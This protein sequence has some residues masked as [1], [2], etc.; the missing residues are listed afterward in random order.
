V[1]PAECIVIEDSFAGAQAANSAGM[2]V[3]ALLNGVNSRED[4][5]SL[6]I[7]GFVAD[8]AQLHDALDS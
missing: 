2:N 5:A 6:E 3:Y 4:F 7:D 1:H 8:I